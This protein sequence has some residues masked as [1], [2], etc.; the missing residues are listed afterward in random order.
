MRQKA[1]QSK[2][3]EQK[4]NEK[5]IKKSHR[6]KPDKKLIQKGEIDRQLV[7]FNGSP[8]GNIATSGRKEI[9]KKERRKYI[10]I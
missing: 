8:D 7:I 5:Q 2:E 6:S 9:K 1:N 4:N 3:Q 10:K